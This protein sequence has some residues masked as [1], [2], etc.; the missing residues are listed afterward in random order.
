M[1]ISGSNKILE[2]E[3]KKL[4]WAVKFLS[5]SLYILNNIIGMDYCQQ[6]GIADQLLQ[7]CLVPVV[8]NPRELTGGVWFRCRICGK[9]ELTSKLSLHARQVHH[10][11]HVTDCISRYVQLAIVFC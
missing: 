7:Q 11:D 9:V 4:N 3:R 6:H 1:L 5:I 8:P 10:T 2:T